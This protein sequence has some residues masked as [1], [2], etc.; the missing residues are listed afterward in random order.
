MPENDPYAALARPDFRLLLIGRLLTTFAL[1]IQA[2]AVGWQIYALTKDAFFLGMIGLAE[3]LPS[4]GVALYAGHVAD[5]VE[6]RTIVLTVSASLVLSVALLAGCSAALAA[7]AMLVPIIFCIIA[8]SGLARGFYAP[9]MFGMVSDVVPRELYGNA[10]AW[11]TATW[12]ASSVAGPVLGGLLYV[13]FGPAIT[14]AFATVFLAISLFCFFGVKATPVMKAKNDVSVFENIKEGVRF[15]FSNQVILAAMALD[16]FAVLFGGAVALLPIFTSEI[17]HM[18][19]HGL[20]LLRAA[21]GVGSFL[22][23]ALLTHRPLARHT[24][25]ILLAS[26]AGFGFC[27][28]GFGVSTSFYFSLFLLALS[29]ALDGVSIYVR[30]TI[31]Q[32]L[33]PSDM[34]GRVAA[35]NS[36]F[37]GSSNEIG[38][39]ESGVAAKLMGLV[40]SVVFGGC[41]TLLVV[42]AA[43]IKAP[44]L[45][46]LHMQQLHESPASDES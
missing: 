26:V 43:T 37:I 27:M 16:L 30:T 45:R 29:G 35:V 32:L 10:A 15:V 21:P 24:G 13:Y 2:I 8:V 18:G 33:T 25:A 40:P 19:P 23:A 14:Y 28:I 44:K 11:N 9:A 31:I 36:I 12:Q 34:K 22:M 3:A 41:M 7:S 20:G 1:Q 42:L 39:F 17:F 4:L 6:R 46:A 38:E 5:V